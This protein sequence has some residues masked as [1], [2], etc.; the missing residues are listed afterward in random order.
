VFAAHGEALASEAPVFVAHAPEFTAGVSDMTARLPRE[1]DNDPPFPG[2][3]RSEGRL[4]HEAPFLAAHAPVFAA[5]ALSLM[6]DCLGVR[7]WALF[8]RHKTCSCHRLPVHTSLDAA[9]VTNTIF[10]CLEREHVNS[11]GSRVRPARTKTF[12]MDEHM[13]AGSPVPAVFEASE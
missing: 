9:I 4:G 5:T 3:C 8:S 13:T 10:G 2:A 12:G 7:T 6:L 1:I 11:T